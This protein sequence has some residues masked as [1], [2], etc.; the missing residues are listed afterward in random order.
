M[1]LLGYTHNCKGT[2]YSGSTRFDHHCRERRDGYLYEGQSRVR[3]SPELLRVFYDLT[4]FYINLMCVCIQ[5][6]PLRKQNQSLIA[7]QECKSSLFFFTLVFVLARH[8]HTLRK[9]RSG[10]CKQVEQ[11]DDKDEDT[12]DTS[13]HS[14]RPKPNLPRKMTFS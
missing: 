1:C 8:H 7:H 2:V 13:L 12:H 14:G 10:M 5:E 9:H 6:S 3:Y 4:I 11:P